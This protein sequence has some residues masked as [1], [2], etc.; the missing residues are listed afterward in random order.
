MA[1]F[2]VHNR[3]VVDYL[4]DGLIVA[5]GGHPHILESSL[6]LLL[7]ELRSIRNYVSL[8]LRSIVPGRQAGQN[9]RCLAR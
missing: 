1:I 2:L 4:A 6:D 5:I 7:A 3:F 9:G 8:R